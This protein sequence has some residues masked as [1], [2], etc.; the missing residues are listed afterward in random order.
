[1]RTNIE[2]N[3]SLINEAQK[4]SKVAT[5]KKVVELALENFIKM[6]KRKK[7]L[8]YRGKVVWEGNLDEMRKAF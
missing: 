2:I 4:L 3:Q 1:M 8:D 6:L 7:M 5:K